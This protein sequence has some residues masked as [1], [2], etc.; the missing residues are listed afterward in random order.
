M[1]QGRR[2]GGAAG[3]GALHREVDDAVAEALEDDVA[4]VAR[5]RG[6]DP[7]LDQFL[8]RL[9]RF[10]VLLVEELAGRDRVGAA[11]GDQRLARQIE[12]CDNAEHCGPQVL[13]L[14]VGLGHRNEVIG[15]EY[16]SDARQ[17]HER[18]G[19]RRALGRLE[20]ARLERALLHHRAPGQEFEGRG[21]GGRFGL[22]EHGALLLRPMK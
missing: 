21:I 7:R 18:L 11:L 5:H 3:A 1:P 12:L 20:V 2:R 9:D 19:E 15:E 6:P 14:A 22:N 10:G 4:A 16:A 17:L 8:D 13:P